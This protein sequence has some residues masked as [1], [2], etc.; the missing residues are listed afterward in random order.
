V[1]GLG[2]PPTA[3]P[4]HNIAS[5]K[6]FQGAFLLTRLF[7]Y[8]GK[9]LFSWFYLPAQFYPILPFPETM[10]EITKFGN[11]FIAHIYN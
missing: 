9:Y 4:V 7:S 8:L 6:F 1:Q 2:L 10:M 3:A 5:A 11:Q